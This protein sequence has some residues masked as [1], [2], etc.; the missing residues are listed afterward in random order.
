MDALHEP[1]NLEERDFRAEIAAEARAYAESGRR[2]IETLVVNAVC[3]IVLDDPV[4][5]ARQPAWV[6]TM[7][8][9]L[10]SSVRARIA[11]LRA[12]R[13]AIEAELAG[14]KLQRQEFSAA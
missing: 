8:D 7:R 13:E 14:V 5:L 4:S 9:N 1:Q 2:E 12:E 3:S 6:Q 11:E 10:D